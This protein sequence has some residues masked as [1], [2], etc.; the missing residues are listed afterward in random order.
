VITVYYICEINLEEEIE[1]AVNVQDI[2]LDQKA[3]W[4][5]VDMKRL[6]GNLRASWELHIR[7]L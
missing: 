7:R 6:P 5:D 1:N 3:I 2:F 4:Y